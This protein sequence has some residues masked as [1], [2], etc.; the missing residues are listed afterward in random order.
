MS[1][2]DIGRDEACNFVI[3]SDT[4]S[5]FHAQVESLDS[6]QVFIQ[7]QRSRNGTFLNRTG[8][9]IQVDRVTLCVGDRIRFGE[10][11]VTLQQLTSALPGNTRLMPNTSVYAMVMLESKQELTTLKTIVFRSH[12]ET[13]QPA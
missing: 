13:R 11:E 3:A 12:E 10:H 4:V 1:A 8:E 6:G 5:R 2:I 9:W 7:D